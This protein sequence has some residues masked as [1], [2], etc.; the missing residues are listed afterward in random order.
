LRDTPPQC[1]ILAPP[2]GTNYGMSSCSDCGL[3]VDHCHGT[4]VVHEDST[5]DCTDVMCEL[6]DLL[7]HA[8]IVDCVAVLGGCCVTEEAVDFAVAS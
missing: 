8:F 7:R 6:P 4:L 5:V 3:E 2:A 1:R